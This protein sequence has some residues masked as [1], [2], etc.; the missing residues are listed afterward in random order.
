MY[1]SGA[2]WVDETSSKIPSYEVLTFCVQLVGCQ[3]VRC[4]DS[5][6]E[7]GL[8]LCFPS[9]HQCSPCVSGDRLEVG[10]VRDE[11]AYQPEYT[12]SLALW[13]AFVALIGQ[14]NSSAKH[15]TRYWKTE[16]SHLEFSKL[17]ISA[18]KS[19]PSQGP[20]L[21]HLSWTCRSH[22]W[23]IQCLCLLATRHFPSSM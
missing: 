12:T 6:C 11:V 9:D 14:G 2:V 18:A 19:R 1:H 15:Q 20:L 13:F 16:A 5:V 10:D 8:K 4:P 7:R 17:A 3:C 23:S 22:T 21:S